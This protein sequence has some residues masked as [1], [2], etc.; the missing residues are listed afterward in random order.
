MADPAKKSQKSLPSESN[1]SKD[2]WGSFTP[3][4]TPVHRREEFGGR[5]LLTSTKSIMY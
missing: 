4:S 5:A 1:C 2:P 3:P